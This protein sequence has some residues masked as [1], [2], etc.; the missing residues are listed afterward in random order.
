MRRIATAA[1]L[2]MLAGSAVAADFRP[3]SGPLPMSVP[4]WTGFYLGVNA[5]GGWA[6]A[7]I[8]FSLGGVPFAAVDNS[9]RGALG[10]VQAGYN[11]QAGA[12]LLGVE[13]DAQASGV[14][15]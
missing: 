12:I 8:D 4:G 6:D 11:W 9:M 1:S 13:A 5:G 7:Q 2:A 14:Q 10:G 3:P 15:G